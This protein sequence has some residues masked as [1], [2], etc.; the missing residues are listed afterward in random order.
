M[1]KRRRDAD[2]EK[3]RAVQREIMRRKYREVKTK[4]RGVPVG[5]VRIQRKSRPKRVG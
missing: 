4:Q 1:S 5:K 3:Y 2:P